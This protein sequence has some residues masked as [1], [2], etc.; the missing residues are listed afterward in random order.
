MIP[1]G[2]D[3]RIEKFLSS[4]KLLITKY[5]HLDMSL[6]YHYSD[7]SDIEA[8]CILQPWVSEG[9]EEAI[10]VRM[11]GTGFIKRPL[12]REEKPQPAAKTQPLEGHDESSRFQP[13]LN[14]ESCQTCWEEVPREHDN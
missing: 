1:G 11:G 9:R 2:K 4:Q 3:H 6:M 12:T 14:T 10:T 7:G 13:A 5:F 8:Y